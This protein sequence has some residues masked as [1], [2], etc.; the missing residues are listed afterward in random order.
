MCT[1]KDNW[2]GFSNKKCEECKIAL[3]LAVL[4]EKDGETKAL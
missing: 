3:D 2:I 1:D 4:Y